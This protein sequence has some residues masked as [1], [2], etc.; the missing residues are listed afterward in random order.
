MVRLH[1]RNVILVEVEIK[2]VR[3]GGYSN[4]IGML[5]V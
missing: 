3:K 5:R 1:G 4:S 2:K